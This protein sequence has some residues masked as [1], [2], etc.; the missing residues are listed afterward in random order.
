MRNLGRS[1]CGIS[2]KMATTGAALNG[3]AIHY[4]VMPTV[5][6]PGGPLPGDADRDRLG[7]QGHA[8]RL[9]DPLAHGAGQGLDVGATRAS[10]VRQRQHVLGGQGRARRIPGLGQVEALGA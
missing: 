1:F 5:T 7:H 10:A 3:H 9:K 2:G 6:R 4:H 8:E